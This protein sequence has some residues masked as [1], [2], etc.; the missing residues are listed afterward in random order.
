VNISEDW[1]QLYGSQVG[2]YAYQAYLHE[3]GH[4]LGLGHPGNYNVVAN[5]PYD[6][7]FLNDSWATTIMS[8]FSQ[9]ESD[10]FADLGFT[11][12]YLVTPM[13][14]DI[15][16]V[17]QLYGLSTTTRSGNTTYGFNSNA[18]NQIYNANV[19]TGG[20]TNVAL[21]IFDTGGIDTLDYSGSAADQR[22]DLNPESFSNVLGQRGNLSIARGTIIENA[23]GGSGVDVI[24]GN[25]SGNVLYGR[26]GDDALYGRA[27][28]DTLDGGSGADRMV[29][30]TGNDRYRV[31]DSGDRIVELAGEGTDTVYASASYGLRAG[32]AVEFLRTSNEA[33]TTPINLNGNEFAQTIVGN[34]GANKI[35]GGGGNDVLN[36]GAGI[37]RMYGGLGNDSYYVDNSGDRPNE[38]SGQGSDTVYSSISY[39]LRSGMSIEYL[40]TTN[41]G[42]ATAINLTGNEFGQ[43]I[44]GNAGANTLNGRGGD[45]TL[46]GGAGNDRLYG[47]ANN[48]VL[49]GGAGLDRMAGG[50]GNDRY[51]VDSAGDKVTEFAG[52]GTDTIYASV[53]YALGA[54][55]AVEYLRAASETATTAINLTGNEFAQTL[56]GNAGA[57]VLNGG[58]GNDT[59]IGR[60]GADTFVFS[61][62][63]D[64]DRILD[65]VS[66]IDRID[67]SGI[68]ANASVDGNQAFN[69]IDDAAFSGAAGELRTYVSEGVHYVAG[70]V[71]GDG[72]ADFTIILGTATV[73]SG[74]FL[75]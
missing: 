46:Y 63:G 64:T 51:R 50:T 27:G 38:I 6:A 10:Y 18:G 5:Y 13:V 25:S 73:Q 53:S 37:D 7:A 14:A 21:T 32:V 8:Y 30:G 43:T 15:L 42:A 28:N 23:I 56:S 31:N 70:D 34:A 39:G 69:F 61:N 48:D 58:A 2:G 40:R 72:I 66:G 12:L 29:G 68:D 20:I 17:Q 11:E 36:G 19:S 35:N 47:G 60:G 44:V 4:A 74:D 49:D 1:L 3:I 67:L 59:L 22:I 62:L 41:A 57:N 24:V 26:N 9:E 45:D 71:N 75:L 54:G 55:S 33:G 65:F 16:A 52:E